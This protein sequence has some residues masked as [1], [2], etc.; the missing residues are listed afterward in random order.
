MRD[1]LVSGFIEM[2]SLART[3]R[4]YASDLKDLASF[5]DER[6]RLPI[7]VLQEEHALAWRRELETRGLAPATISRK[8]AVARG[9]FT[10]LLDLDR[11]PEG[12]PPR[13]PFRRVRAP[14]FDRSVGKT[15]CPGPNEVA[16][17]LRVIKSRS[18]VGRRD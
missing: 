1:G 14:R 12:L 5:A 2:H 7:Y 17:L 16:R 15:P 6:V 4:V 10:Y 13:N 8:L 9:L 11:P 3:R 18:R